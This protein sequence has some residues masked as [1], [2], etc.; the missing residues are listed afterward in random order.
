ME[1]ERT[2]QA[3]LS[4]LDP[5]RF[6][7]AFLLYVFIVCGF[8]IDRFIKGE[9]YLAFAFPLLLVSGYFIRKL[10]LP[11]VVRLDIS[12][13]SLTKHFLIFKRE[14]RWEEVTSCEEETIKGAVRIFAYA[15][16][17]FTVCRVY[18]R[19]GKCIKFDSFFINFEELVDLAKQH[20]PASVWK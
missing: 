20:T 7:V 2:K 17:P 19:D 11:F 13:L 4:H 18:G 8:L 3:F 12:P 6:G 1:D 5:R 9:W 15:A 10:I 14:I 16:E